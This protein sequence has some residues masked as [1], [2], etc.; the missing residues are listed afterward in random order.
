MVSRMSSM[1]KHLENLRGVSLF[2]GCSKK[3]LERIAKA[4]DEI[5][6]PAGTVLMEQDKPGREAFVIMEGEVIVKRNN[7]KVATLGPGRVVGELSLIDNGTRTATVVC[8]TECELFVIDHRRFGG[9]IDDVPALSHKVMRSLA[10]KIRELD[11]KAY[12]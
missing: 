2:S 12:G 1:K 9:V 10:A 7:R 5:T 4:G 3:D 8:T 6:R 11:T